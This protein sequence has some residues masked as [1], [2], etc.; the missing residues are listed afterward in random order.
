[1]VYSVTLN[2]HYDFHYDTALAT[3]GI[4]RGFVVSSWQEQ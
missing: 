3:N 1:V 4:S 2:G